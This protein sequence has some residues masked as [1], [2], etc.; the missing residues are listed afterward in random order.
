[1]PDLSPLWDHA[2]PIASVLGVL[3][4]WLL[5]SAI[6]A[7]FRLRLLRSLFRLVLGALLLA[8][9]ALVAGISIGTRGYHALVREDVAATIDIRPS[10]TQR[11]AATLT[12]PD[13]RTRELAL[14][15]DEV[16]V[17]ARVL[18]WTPAANMMGLHT[19]YELDRI[20]G[21]YRDVN[22]ERSLPR[23]V[24]ALG[25]ERPIDMFALRKRYLALGALVDAEYGS[26]SFVPAHETSRWELRVSTSG[27]LIRPK[28]P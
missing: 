3:A 10:G 4:V 12:F 8:G 14:S 25:E 9:A 6:G 23:S 21:R 2:L 16:Y 27:L 15:G 17:D 1:M 24:Y 7:L 28:S 19:V 18:K 11:F 5:L 22:Q 26:G 13:G 20:S